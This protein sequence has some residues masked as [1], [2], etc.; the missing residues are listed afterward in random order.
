MTA[1]GLGL[2]G[3]LSP[4]AIPGTTSF[5]PAIAGTTFTADLADGIGTAPTLSRV[6]ATPGVLTD[7]VGSLLSQAVGRV[8][9]LTDGFSASYL[10]EVFRT[11]PALAEDDIGASGS[12]TV[13]RGQVL[14]EQLRISLSQIPNTRTRH[15]LAQAMAMA[16]DLKAG[17]PVTLSNGV[18]IALTHQEQLCL[19]VIE[20]L[21]LASVIAAKMTYGRTL[22]ETVSVA[23]TLSKFLGASLSSGIGV[24]LATTVVANKAGTLTDGI[25]IAPV[26]TPRLVLKVTAHDTIGIDPADALRMLFRGVISEGVELA[27]AYLSPGDSVVTWAVNTRT[28]AVSQYDNYAF[29]SFARVGNKYIGASEDGLFELVGDDDNGTDIVAQIKSGFAQWA[30]SKFTMFKAI[31]L[32]VRGEGDFVLRLVTGDGD[33]YNYGVSTRDMRSTRVHLGKGL[34]ARYFAFELISTGQDFDLDT[35]EFVPLVAERRV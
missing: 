28:G 12:L 27:G 9:T 22:T 14:L 21:G 26:M 2:G 13:A 5:A 19:Q 32:G 20:E 1:L 33:T 17:I 23:S 34:R 18:G 25:G 8:S 4:L 30:G 31:Y 7:G 10:I 16:S 29:N 3:S 15:T 24:A 11:Q 35:I 6:Y